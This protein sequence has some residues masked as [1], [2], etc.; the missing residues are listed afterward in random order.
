MI[1]L[2]LKQPLILESWVVFLLQRGEYAGDFTA[3]AG[4]V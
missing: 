4:S 2:A 3:E 1:I